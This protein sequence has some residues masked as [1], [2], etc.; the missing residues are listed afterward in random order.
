MNREEALK[1]LGLN[2]NPSEED[3]RKARNTL[4]LQYHPDKNSDKE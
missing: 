3:I 4:A 2:A 1:I